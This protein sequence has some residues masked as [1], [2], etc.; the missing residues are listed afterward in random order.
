MII[1]QFN[2]IFIRQHY[3][4]NL[5]EFSVIICTDKKALEYAMGGISG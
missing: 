2:G 3:L 1:S 5:F 4:L